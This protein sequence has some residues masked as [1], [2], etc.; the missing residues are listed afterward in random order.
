MGRSTKWERHNC[1]LNL[2]SVL[3]YSIQDVCLFFLEDICSFSIAISYC[4]LNSLPWILD[5]M[6]QNVK[7]K[8]NISSGHRCSWLRL[9]KNPQ[10]KPFIIQGNFTKSQILS[11]Q[12]RS[13]HTVTH[14][15]TWKLPSTISLIRCQLC[16][17][18]GEAW[19]IMVCLCLGR[20]GGGKGGKARAAVLLP[21][22]GFILLVQDLKCFSN[23][24]GQHFPGALVYDLYQYLKNNG[25]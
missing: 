7:C 16:S 5:L 6:A 23:L 19:R 9:L 24:F 4:C 18:S 10:K 12:E 8:E 22:P 15:L 1:P 17:S 21:P 2:S 20:L 25:F 3:M 14:I 11:L 13:D